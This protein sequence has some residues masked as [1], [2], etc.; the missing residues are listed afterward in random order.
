[1]KLL[2]EIVSNIN[3]SLTGIKGTFF[4]AGI[5]RVVL[6]DAVDKNYIGEDQI[7]F[8][9]KFQN[10][11]YHKIVSETF[12]LLQSRGK[13]KVFNRTATMDLLVMTEYR[14]FDDYLVSKLSDV[15]HLNIQ[16]IDWDSVGIYR[17][18]VGN[19]NSYDPKK[20]VFA[21]RYQVVYK[22]ECY[23]C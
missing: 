6:H 13:R 12:D 3:C 14:D 16:G 8:D 9:D 2:D 18:E 23:E 10:Y 5:A 17:R 11:F 7:T 1:M 22:T 19:L 4:S 15:N 21:I 20:Y